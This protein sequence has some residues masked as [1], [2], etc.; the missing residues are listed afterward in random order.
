MNRSRIVT[1]ILF[2]LVMIVLALLSW[3]FGVLAKFAAGVAVGAIPGIV[4]YLHGV[5]RWK[6]WT[7]IFE[8]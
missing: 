8:E 5:R 3:S 6:S 4:L 1:V 7:W 2:F